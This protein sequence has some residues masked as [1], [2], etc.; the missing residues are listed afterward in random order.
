MKKLL[1][2]ESRAQISASRFASEGVINELRK[3]LSSYAEFCLQICT[4]CLILLDEM[5]ANAVVYRV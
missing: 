3:I 2:C 1:V 5:S 4:K